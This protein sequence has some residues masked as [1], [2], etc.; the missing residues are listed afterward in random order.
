MVLGNNDI[1]VLAQLGI[2]VKR[3]NITNPAHLFKR[4][5]TGGM[6]S[7]NTRCRSPQSFKRKFY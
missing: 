7:R 3:P 4:T 6:S 2:I 1:R 5:G